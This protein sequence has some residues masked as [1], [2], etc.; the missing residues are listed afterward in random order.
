MLARHR[1]ERRHGEFR[2]PEKDH[3]HGARFYVVVVAA[4]PVVVV[5][6]G[7]LTTLVAVVALVAVVGGA[8]GSYGATMPSA[9][10]LGCGDSACIPFAAGVSFALCGG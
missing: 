6:G 3:A 7:A 9:P 1:L 2:S 10:L 8:T 4:V 5:T